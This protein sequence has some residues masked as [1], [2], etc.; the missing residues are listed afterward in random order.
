MEQ[1]S[2]L[3]RPLLAVPNLTAKQA[4]YLDSVVSTGVISAREAAEDIGGSAE[5]PS[6]AVKTLQRLEELGLVE[7]IRSRGSK[8]IFYKASP[9]GEQVA[10]EK[11]RAASPTIQFAQDNTEAVEVYDR[12]RLSSVP[13]RTVME[14]LIWLAGAARVTL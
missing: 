2:P 12:L 9:L 1:E 6:T 8:R 13:G 5:R 10:S 7:S 14:K 4:D 11:A 3:H